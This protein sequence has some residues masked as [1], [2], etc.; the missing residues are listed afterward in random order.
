MNV[1][2][3]MKSVD[4]GGMGLGIWVD[5]N[6]YIVE[7]PVCNVVF[8]VKTYD[9]LVMK[10][11]PFTNILRGCTASKV[12]EIGQKL[13]HLLADVCQ[14]PITLYEAKHACEI[15]TTSGDTHINP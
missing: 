11:P 1:L 3:S 14:A 12:L 15:F 4:R 9:G 7:G 2:M 6:G 5:E 13:K 10:T 8:V